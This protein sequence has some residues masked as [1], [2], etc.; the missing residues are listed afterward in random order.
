MKVRCTFR[1]SLLCPLGSC[2]TID[3]DL[4]GDMLWVDCPIDDSRAPIG[5]FAVNLTS[6]TVVAPLEEPKGK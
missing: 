5:R 4:R 3:G 6:R 2:Q 1:P